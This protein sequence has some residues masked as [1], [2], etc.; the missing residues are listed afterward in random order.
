MDGSVKFFLRT[1]RHR[2]RRAAA[3]A[4]YG[5]ALRG[6]PVLFANS[7]P[8]SGTHLLTQIL[9]GFARFGP[10]VDAGLPAVLTYESATG[11]ERTPA[12]IAADLRRLRP[13]DIG[14]GH[15]HALPE[16]VP[17]LCRPGVA[18]W[19]IVRDPRDVVV[20][21]VHYVTDMAPGH[22]HHAYYCSLPDFESRLRVSILG[23]PDAEVPFPDISQRFAPYR[24]WLEQPEVSLLHFEDFLQGR[25]AALGAV[26]DHAVRRGFPLKIP[27]EEA[28]S[29]LEAAI[30]PEKSPTFRSGKA[31]G[32]RESFTPETTALFKDVAGDLL[33]ALGYESDK[34]W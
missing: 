11:R 10:A 4:R 12:E 27:R 30:N 33:I 31:G 14:Y 18:T 6:A 32:W 34:D 8:K 16:T 25:R 24:G 5:P 26:L 22:V 7:F 13:G 20:S 1:L 29:L 23:L 28:I 3:F 2:L 21:H 17:L 9:E 15:V 19:F